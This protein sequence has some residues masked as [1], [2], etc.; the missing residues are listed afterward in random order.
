MIGSLAFYHLA[1]RPNKHIILLVY[2]HLDH[3]PINTIKHHYNSMGDQPWDT[4]IP[5]PFF[6]TFLTETHLHNINNIFKIIKKMWVFCLHSI[7]MLPSCILGTIPGPLDLY[8]PYGSISELFDFLVQNAHQ[9]HLESAFLLPLNHIPINNIIG[10]KY[11]F[12]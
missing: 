12:L 8:K 11:I 9:M 6:F 1:L 3:Q 10:L 7:F 2:K 5:S 4:T